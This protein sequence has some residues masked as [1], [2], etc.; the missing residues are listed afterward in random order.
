[1]KI[2]LILP[3]YGP[4]ATRNGLLD[5]ALAAE[6]LGFDS[7]WLTDHLAL[8]EKDAGQFGR[9]FEST[10]S[11]AFLAASTNTIRLGISTLV[12]PQRN[13]VEIAKSL[14]TLDVLSNGRILLTAGIGWSQGEYRNLGYNFQNRAVR[15]NEALK[16]LRTIWSGQTPVSFKGEYYQFEDM[17]LSPKPVQSGGPPLWVAGNSIHALKRAVLLADGWHPNATSP[18]NL[19]NQLDQVK[20]LLLNRTF[21]VAVRF[22]LDF[23]KNEISEGMLSGSNGNIIN[24]LRKY[25]ASGMNY[26]LINFKAYSQAERERFM[27][28]FIHEIKPEL[29]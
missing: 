12:L 19:Q 15:M 5:S 10:T 3:N 4:D 28:R 2:G 21:T 1:M 8:P 9:I 18:E 6:K 14:A 20:N 16:V 23:N 29:S 26:A 24:Q 22:K 11:L 25:K 17:V 7:I 27:E 13:P